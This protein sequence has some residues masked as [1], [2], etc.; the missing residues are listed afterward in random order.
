M[1]LVGARY[2]CSSLTSASLCAVAPALT[3]RRLYKDLLSYCPSCQ[4]VSIHRRTCPGSPK[5]SPGRTL[6]EGWPD[7]CT[8]I[9]YTLPDAQ[10]FARA[11]AQ[12]LKMCIPTSDLHVHAQQD[13]SCRYL[14][15]AEISN[16]PTTH[17][18]T[19]ARSLCMPPCVTRAACWRTHPWWH[20]RCH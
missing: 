11:L 9:V 18:N 6:D 16:Q 19:H 20:S 8:R 1:A 14:L 2:S 17:G 4:H 13:I 15:T 5:A 3:Y 10:I 12:Q 7:A